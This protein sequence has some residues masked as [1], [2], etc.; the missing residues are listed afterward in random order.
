MVERAQNFF[1]VW[2]EEICAYPQQN[3]QFGDV[4][5]LSAEEIL[6]RIKRCYGE[7]TVWT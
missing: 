7:E 5:N 6:K 4:E 1:H 3:E 2:V